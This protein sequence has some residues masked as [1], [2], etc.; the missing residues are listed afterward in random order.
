MRVMIIGATGA[1][2]I[3]LIRQLRE[4]GHE[5]IGTSRSQE[6]AAHL[7]TLGAHPIVL[8]ALDAPAVHTS[9]AAARPEAIIYQA[10]GLAGVRILRSLDRPFAVT[11]RL[12]TEGLDNVLAAA[13]QAGVRRIVAQSFAPYRYAREGGWVKTEDDPLDPAPPA[14]ARQTFAAMDHLDRAVTEAGG[15]ALRYGGFY[16]PGDEG[17]TRAVR[18]RQTPLVGDGQ[19]VMSFVHLDDA[20]AATVL[21]LAHDGPAIYNIVDDEPAPMRDWLPVLA[22]AV[23]AKS[24]RHVP[25][26]IAR[27]IAGPGLTMLTE[28]RGSSNA[29]ASRELGWQPRYPSWREGLAVAYGEQPSTASR[30]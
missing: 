5:V 30:S 13:R 9:V 2:G 19:G 8:D 20:A 6:R 17:L 7:G 23:G 29:K 22:Q 1:V 28:A 11:N 15:T 14:S 18:K 21:A 3:P 12:R 4:A 25:K 27:V 16:G 24:P 10:T 26:W